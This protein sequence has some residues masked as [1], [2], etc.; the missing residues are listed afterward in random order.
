V[1]LATYFGQN[2]RSRR[3][4]LEWALSLQ[5]SRI[6]GDGKKYKGLDLILVGKSFSLPRLF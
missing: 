5:S 4:K 1:L 2:E 6:N 3:T